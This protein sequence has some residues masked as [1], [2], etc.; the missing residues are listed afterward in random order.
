MASDQSAYLSTVRKYS[1]RGKS[2]TEH[3]ALKN[4]P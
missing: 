1:S 3:L 4:E 2:N